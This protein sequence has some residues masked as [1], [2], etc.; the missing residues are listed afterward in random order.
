M[1]RD[2][3]DAIRDTLIPFCACLA[4]AVIA[5]LFTRLDVSCAESRVMLVGGC[6]CDG[7]CAVMFE[8][9]E[10]ATLHLPVEGQL[11]KYRITK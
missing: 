10:T 5:A 9:G 1:T 6:N 4:F 11:R 3:K 7:L 2:G 8:N